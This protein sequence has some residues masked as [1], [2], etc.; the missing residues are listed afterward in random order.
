MNPKTVIH[1][2][3]QFGQP[4]GS[5]RRCCQECGTMTI[6]PD[7]PPFTDDPETWGKTEVLSA[8]GYIRCTNVLAKGG[9]PF[10]STFEGG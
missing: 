8:S 10:S 3:T 1:L 6:G 7:A 2:V 4:Y 5:V 9:D